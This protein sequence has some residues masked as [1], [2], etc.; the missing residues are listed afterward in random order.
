MAQYFW[1]PDPADV[2][3][4]PS[5]LVFDQPASSGG[6]A[7]TEIIQISE[8]GWDTYAWNL[9]WGSNTWNFL[10]FVSFY[11]ET[12]GQSSE[13]EI[14]VEGVFASGFSNMAISPKVWLSS[15]TAYKARMRHGN[16]IRKVGPG[17]NFVE[18]ASGNTSDGGS[19]IR[20]RVGDGFQKIKWWEA[21]EFD[22]EEPTNWLLETSDA[23]FTGVADTGML[24]IYSNTGACRLV[25]IGIGTDGDPAPTT[26]VP[27]GPTTPT[28]LITS[29][30]TANSFRAGWTP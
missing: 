27:V 13:V 8:W 2:G 1:Q 3:N 29:N 22:V 21:P 6:I 23:D 11:S 26:P 4:P 20:M 18:L 16:H 10:R 17:R 9:Q 30:I 14:F 25:S 7:S 15:E 24:N 5:D 28:G 19:R 12:I